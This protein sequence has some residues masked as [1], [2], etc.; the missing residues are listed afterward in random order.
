M[1]ID[2]TTLQKLGQPDIHHVKL[3]IDDLHELVLVSSDTIRNAS[4]GTDQVSIDMNDAAKWLFK[5]HD[6]A[7]PLRA[8]ASAINR[9]EFQY[10]HPTDPRTANETSIFEFI[11][12]LVAISCFEH[13]PSNRICIS[14]LSFKIS[15]SCIIDKLIQFFYLNLYKMP[16]LIS[17]QLPRH[18]Q[19]IA[20]ANMA[21]QL[22]ILAHENADVEYMDE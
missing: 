14:Q 3:N 22:A 9:L 15:S 2:N 5:L 19:Y 13:T 18:A 16:Q 8:I 11:S 20:E 21:F 4:S 1:I 17:L 10:N 6:V 12:N 7:W